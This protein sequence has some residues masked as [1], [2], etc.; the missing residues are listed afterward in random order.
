MSDGGGGRV[1]YRTLDEQAGR[2]SE[3]EERFE[4]KQR[5]PGGSGAGRARLVGLTG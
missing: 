3:A 1:T 5:E 2:L 4:R